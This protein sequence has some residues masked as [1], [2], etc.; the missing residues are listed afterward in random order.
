M[1]GS[2]YIKNGN[3]I[4]CQFTVVQH[5]FSWWDIKL[6]FSDLMLNRKIFFWMYEVMCKK[7]NNSYFNK[8]LI[9]MV[10]NCQGNSLV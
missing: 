9:F 2:K 8:V 10:E 5:Y 1:F 3:Y 7:K 4:L 6:I